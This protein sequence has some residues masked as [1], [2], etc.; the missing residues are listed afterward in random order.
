MTN[1]PRYKNHPAQLCPDWQLTELWAKWQQFLN[2]Q[3]LKLFI[4]P[5]NVIWYNISGLDSTY[6]ECHEQLVRGRTHS[7]PL[8]ASLICVEMSQRHSGGHDTA[9]PYE[10]QDH[11]R[12]RSRSSLEE[13]M[14]LACCSHW[15]TLDPFLLSFCFLT[16]KNLYSM[17]LNT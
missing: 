3:I 6:C 11:G 14:G 7:W 4:T 1:D 13:V 10:H 12:G 8:R 5:K 2:H 9:P 17:F 16:Q 15:C